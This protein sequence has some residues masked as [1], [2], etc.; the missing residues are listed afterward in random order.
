[1]PKLSLTVELNELATFDRPLLLKRFRQLYNAMP[2]TTI[3]RQ[4]LLQ[5]VAYR[6][7]EQALGS[8]KPAARRFLAQ[9]PTNK[10]ANSISMTNLRIGTRLLRE[11]HGIT[12]EVTILEH[13]VMYNGTEYGS[14]TEVT[15]AITGS[16]W[17]GP[18]F[19]GLRKKLHG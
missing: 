18:A 15:R 19:F 12:H 7:Q 11:W 1:M 2:P 10:K 4:L 3:S 6:M 14:L 5:V 9:F 8:L 16:K 17:S 13:G